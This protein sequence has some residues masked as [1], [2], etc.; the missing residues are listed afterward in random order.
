MSSYTIEIA[1]SEQD[2]KILKEG[3]YSLYAFKAVKGSGSGGVTVWNKLKPKQLSSSMNIVW[4][5]EFLAYNSHSKIENNNVIKAGASIQ[6][7]PGQLVE[8]DRYGNLSTNKGGLEGHISF[9]NFDRQVYTI[10]FDEKVGSEQNITCAFSILG[11]GSGKVFVPLNKIALII[12]SEELEVNTVTQWAISNGALID[13]ESAE[14][15]KRVVTFSADLGWTKNKESW[16][17]VFNAFT[18]MADLLII[19]DS[20]QIAKERSLKNKNSKKK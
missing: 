18:D 11:N 2:V 9:I 8:I 13:V 20:R 19:Q 4:E 3:K 16:V 1:I 14:N 10:G 6:V 7:H 17:K 15:N 5:D 12:S